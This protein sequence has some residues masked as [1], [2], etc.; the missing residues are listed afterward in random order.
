MS[1]FTGSATYT[2]SGATAPVDAL[3]NVG[4]FNSATVAVN[5]TALTATLNASLSISNQNLNLGGSSTFTRG[6]A[7]IGWQRSGTQGNL[8]IACT[9]SN[10]ASQGYDGTVGVI[11]AGAAGASMGGQYRI[12]P[13]RADGQGYTNHIS[14]TIALQAGVN[15]AV[16]Q[17][18]QG[19]QSSGKIGR[20]SDH[21]RTTLAGDVALINAARSTNV[22]ANVGASS[23]IAVSRALPRSRVAQ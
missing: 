17:A 23:T 4:T 11:I 18:A 16:A 22:G 2:L 10:C 13:I 14:G 8:N 7:G 15:P 12:T 3:G 1:S 5:F 6:N 9:G 19:Q 20:W 21:L